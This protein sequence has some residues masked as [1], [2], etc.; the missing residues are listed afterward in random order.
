MNS[1]HRCQPVSISMAI[2]PPQVRQ[3]P[4]RRGGLDTLVERPHEKQYTRKSRGLDGGRGGS[5]TGIGSS[6]PWRLPVIPERLCRPGCLEMLTPP[7]AWHAAGRGTRGNDW[8][9]VLT[10]ALS[11]TPVRVR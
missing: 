7:A 4:G 5:V 10:R 6:R 2:V 8:V 9:N 1:C 3:R 11:R